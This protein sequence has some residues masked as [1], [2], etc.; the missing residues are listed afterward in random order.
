M[1]FWSQEDPL[2]H[3]NCKYFVDHHSRAFFLVNLSWRSKTLVI[4]FLTTFAGTPLQWFDKCSSS[5]E[6]SPRF[7]AFLQ[8]LHKAESYLE[9][10]T[11]LDLYLP[12]LFLMV[13]LLFL[14]RNRIFWV[15][16]HFNNYTVYYFFWFYKRR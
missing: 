10:Q 11:V 12:K 5:F 6:T 9:Q 13:C 16:Y 2:S 1:L 8:Y 7:Q 3:D 14:V 15:K 4:Y